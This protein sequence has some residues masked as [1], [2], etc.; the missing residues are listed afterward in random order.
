MLERARPRSRLVDAARLEG[1]LA[2]AAQASPRELLAAALESVVE[3]LGERGSCILVDGGPRVMLSTH[4]PATKNLP[5]DLARFPEI[6]T[7]LD[8]N[9]VI[10][11]EDVQH[12]PLLAPVR[13]LL[14]P[15]LGS[16]AVVP[17]AVAEQR[18]GVLMVQ[19]QSPRA[20]PPEALA[21]ASLLGSLTALILETRLGKR[22]DLV[23]SGT[24]D[25][26]TAVDPSMPDPDHQRS[27]AGS[28]KRVLVVDDDHEHAGALAQGLRHGGYHVDIATD[29]AEGVRTA[30]DRVPHVILMGVCLPVLDGIRAAERLREDPRTRNVPILFLE[31]IDDLW[32]RTRRGTF[33]RVGFLSPAGRLPELL[34]QVEGTIRGA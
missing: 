19:S 7:A 27:E 15:R 23:F 17:L 25:V 20:M 6:R 1:L 5:V 24:F 2:T 31:A 13:D 26:F 18:L 28:R 29:G 33:D 22:V 11:V 12:D 4:A 3:L 14:S 16:V 21:T 30:Q 32:S 34:S 8:A 9:T 10:A